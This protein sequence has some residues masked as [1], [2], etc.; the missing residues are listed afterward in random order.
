MQENTL[1]VGTILEHQC[2]LNRLFEEIKA[3]A[4]EFKSDP[5]GFL[6]SALRRDGAFGGT[7]RKALFRL[8]LAVGIVVYSA[9]FAAMLVIWTIAQHR[10]ARSDS[11]TGLVVHIP[12]YTPLAILD[13]SNTEGDT[14]G[15]GG[16][17]RNT[18]RLPSAGQ[19]PEFSFRN[20]VIAPTPESNPNPPALPVIETLRVDPKLQP[21]RDDLTPTGLPEG[22]VGPPSAGPG[23][24]NGIGTGKGGGIGSGIDDGYDEGIGGNTNGGRF[25]IGGPRQRVPQPAVDSRP[26]LLNQPRPLYTEQ[27]RQHKIEGIVRVRVLVSPEGKVQQVVLVNPLPDGLNEQAIQAAYQMRFKPAMKNGQPVAYWV[28][29]VVIEFNLR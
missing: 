2:M 15:G 8:G 6:Q 26:V 17:G 23:S 4:R 5:K 19:L 11:N 25:S 21:P 1:F 13:G 3:A 27:A 18:E 9:L 12:L 28:T 22:V 29:N 7:R 10:Y 16:G 14:H 24:D 20:P